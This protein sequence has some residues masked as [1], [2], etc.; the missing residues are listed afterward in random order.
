MFSLWVPRWPRATRPVCPQSLP[1]SNPFFLVLVVARQQIPTIR[2]AP[3][4]VSFFVLN[5]SPFL[6]RNVFLR[7]ALVSDLVPCFLSPLG[8]L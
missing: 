7:T 5:F 2:S 6:D 1:R 4:R 3:T 8:C